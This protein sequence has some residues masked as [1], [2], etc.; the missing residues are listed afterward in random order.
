MGQ[1]LGNLAVGSTVYLNENGSPQSYLV[2]HQGIPSSMYDVS[3]NGTWI[4]RKDII[5]ESDWGYTNAFKKAS[6]W[7][8]LNSVINTFDSGIKEIIKQ[9]KIPYCLGG[10]GVYGADIYSGENGYSCKL[11]LLSGYELGWNQNNS[12]KFPIDGSKLSY[13]GEGTGTTSNNKRIAKLNQNPSVWWTR[14][15]L[16][17]DDRKCWAVAIDGNYSSVNSVIKRGIR[18]AMI[19]PQGLVV[20]DSNNIT[21][22]QVPWPFPTVSTLTAPSLAM[23]GQSIPLSWTPV[24]VSGF[25][26]TYQLQRNA[27][28]GGWTTIYT[29]A[30]AS[31][32]DTA[33]TWTQVQYQVAAVIENVI[34]NYTQSSIIPVSNPFALVISGQDGNLGTLTSNLPYTVSSN[35]GNPI[36]LTCTVNGAQV[37]TLTVESGF[38]YNIPIADLPTGTGTIQITASV[39]NGSETVTQTRTWT[40]YKTPINIPS[41]GGIAQLTQNGQN[42][43]PITVPDAVEAPVYLGGNLNAALNKLGQAALYTKIGSPKYNQVTIDLSKVKVGDE[44]LLPYNNVMVPHIVVQIGNPDTSMYDSSCDGVW[45][46]RKD[47]VTQGKWNAN[48]TNTFA[49]NTIMSA[50]QTYV[51]NYNSEVQSVIKSIKIPYCVGGNENYTVNNLANGFSCKIFPLGC[52]EVGIP[53]SGTLPTDG[54]VLSY[55]QGASQSKRQ[56]YFNGSLSGWWTRTP[57][58]NSGELTAFEITT[59]GG[60][61][62]WYVTGNDGY[63]PCFIMPTTFNHTYYV[64]SSN[65]IHPAQEYTQGGSITDVFGYDVPICQYETGSYVGTGRTGQSNPNNLSFSFNPKLVLI[66]ENSTTA[67]GMF[68]VYIYN[69]MITQNNN[70]TSQIKSSLNQNSLS[71]YITSGIAE[72]QLNEDST[73][74]YYVAIG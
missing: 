39:E 72:N 10:G 57:D 8:V 60:I 58:V 12:S 51:E 59:S 9:I 43:W 73:T 61:F 50:M 29:G 14:S 52:V 2:V 19:M 28:N 48:E 3:C 74:Y 26:V 13:F 44:V 53:V 54:K 37:V 46:L 24:S 20:D 21:S 4:L 7:S 6:F 16:Y 31:Y 25:D 30:D 1:L 56:A 18:P 36:S 47:C 34:R 42:I 17:D 55:F 64:D 62:S 41:T 65:N 32:T 11:F 22:T 63:R 23:Q 27:D 49:G 15:Q 40:Y 66:V 45:L 71:W 5:K 35:T 69:V 68:G 38:A 33:G 70:G 67:N